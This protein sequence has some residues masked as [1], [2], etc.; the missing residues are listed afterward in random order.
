MNGPRERGGESKSEPALHGLRLFSCD[1][2]THQRSDR[3]RCHRR[4]GASRNASYS[5]RGDVISEV[6][7]TFLALLRPPATRPGVAILAEGPRVRRPSTE[8]RPDRHLYARR[9]NR[10]KRSPPPC[11]FSGRCRQPSTS[12]SPTISRPIGFEGQED[13]NCERDR[14]PYERGDTGAALLSLWSDIRNRP[15]S[16]ATQPVSVTTT[17]QPRVQRL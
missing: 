4:A 3:S 6:A 10:G 17:G 11:P 8:F 12:I 5:G 1:V 15:Q 14:G 9:R 16:M 2:E 7:G 13:P